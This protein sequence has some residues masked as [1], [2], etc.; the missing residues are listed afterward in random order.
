MP[1]E[2]K[3]KKQGTHDP[4]PKKRAMAGY[5]KSTYKAVLKKTIKKIGN[6][7]AK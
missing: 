6:D 5:A 7:G 4:G 2:E 1:L 3:M